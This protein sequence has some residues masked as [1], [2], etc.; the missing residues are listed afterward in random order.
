MNLDDTRVRDFI[1]ELKDECGSYKRFYEKVHGVKPTKNEVQTMT[2]YV[3]RSALSLEFILK[4]IDA[5]DLYNVTFEQLCNG[6]VPT[7]RKKRK[8]PKSENQ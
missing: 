8:I 5:F 6:V 3:N 1:K 7:R 2:N 4:V